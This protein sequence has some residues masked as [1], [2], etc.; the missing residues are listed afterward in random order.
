MISPI[1]NSGML[2]RTQDFSVMRQNEDNHS[3]NIHVQIQ[4]RMEKTED[5]NAHS[6]VTKDNADGANTEHD[7]RQEGRNRYVNIRKKKKSDALADE[8]VVVVK[9]KSGFDISI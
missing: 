7:A 1:E 2:M 9:K 4:S 6:V 8:G 5:V 3:G